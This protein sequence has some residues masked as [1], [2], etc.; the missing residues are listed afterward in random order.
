MKDT[1]DIVNLD[2]F[3]ARKAEEKKRKTERIFFHHLMGTYR[4]TSPGKMV[5]VDL[6]DVSEEG[7][8]IQ[9]P[10]DAEKSW[11]TDT[12]NIP[13]RMYF[14]PEN[15]MEVFVDIRNTHATIENGTRYL[16]YGCQIQSEQ[17]TFTAWT[18]FIGFLK[19]FSDVSERDTGNISVG[20][21]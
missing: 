21:L 17:R 14:S 1:T 10:Y 11:P 7:L 15:F 5:P 3:R 2:Q 13:I 18:H 16:R 20:S 4:V 19:A 9:I 8:G 12:A 6:I